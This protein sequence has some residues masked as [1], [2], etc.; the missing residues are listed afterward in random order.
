MDLLKLSSIIAFL[1]AILVLLK[2]LLDVIKGIR[3]VKL[4]LFVPALVVISIAGLVFYLASQDDASPVIPDES[5]INSDTVSQSP[6]PSKPILSLPEK[7]NSPTESTARFSN[8]FYLDDNN[9][10]FKAKF[11][12]S[13]FIDS[14]LCVNS[15]KK[16]CWQNFSTSPTIAVGQDTQQTIRHAILWLKKNQTQEFE[17]FI[18]QSR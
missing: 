5:T 4:K 6:T 14:L 18:S 8:I 17:K 9:Y 11:N 16:L 1:A 10:K 12:G 13:G 15:N 2:S 7:R 3:E